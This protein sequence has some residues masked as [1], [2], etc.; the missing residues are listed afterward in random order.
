[1]LI[2]NFLLGAGTLELSTFISKSGGCIVTSTSWSMAARFR[3]SWVSAKLL[4]IQR[5]EPM[6]KGA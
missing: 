3:V 1:M 6:P 5:C 4:P 2:L